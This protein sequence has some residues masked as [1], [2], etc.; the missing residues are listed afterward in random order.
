MPGN[1]TWST[2]DI[3][4]LTGTTAVVT[5][6]NNGLGFAT[7]RE[8]LLHGAHVVLACRDLDKGRAAVDQL[9]PEVLASVGELRTEVVH[10]DLSI[11]S[12]VHSFA[13]A[14]MASHHRLDLLVNN[15]GV[16]MTPY[17]LTADGHERQFGTNHLG[18]FA[19]T[20]LLLGSLAAAPGSRVISLSSLAHR[21]GTMDFENPLFL[22]GGYTPVAA[23]NRSK[24]AN[25]LFT[26]ELDQRLRAA[27]Q[28]TFAVAAHPG[29]VGTDLFGH[30]FDRPS[31]RPARALFNAVMPRPAQG[32]RPTLRAASDPGVHGGEYFGPGGPGEWRGAPRPAKRAAA[33]QDPESARRLW[34]LSEALTQVSYL[35]APSRE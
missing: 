20:G 35:D 4:D 27:G 9:R 5:G 7:T 29:V 23:Y 2:R 19:L 22:E 24:L 31:L 25:L 14:F 32:A 11:L 8:L 12:T 15:A 17:G 16:M 18:H 28:E 21:G 6:A 30:V 1:R 26:Y 10:L 34:E 13:Q 3:G 33:A